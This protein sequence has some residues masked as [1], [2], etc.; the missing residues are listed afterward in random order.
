MR[1]LIKH[2]KKTLIF[3]SVFF[4]FIIFLLIYSFYPVFIYNKNIENT[5]WNIILYDRNWKLITDKSKKNWYYKKYSRDVSLIYL[6]Q[7]KKDVLE[8]HLYKNKFINSFFF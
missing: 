5:P 8:K 3:L 2:Y 1:N 7:N 4:C 6:N